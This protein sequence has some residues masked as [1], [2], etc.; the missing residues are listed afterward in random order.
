MGCSQASKINFTDEEFKYFQSS[1]KVHKIGMA[2]ESKQKK[3]IILVNGSLHVHNLN[4]KTLDE[5]RTAADAMRSLSGSGKTF[6]CSPNTRISRIQAEV[7]LSYFNWSSGL[8]IPW[9]PF[10][11]RSTIVNF[12]SDLNLTFTNEQEAEEWEAAIK[13]VINFRY[14]TNLLH[15]SRHSQPFFFENLNT[16]VWMSISAGNIAL[17]ELYTNLVWELDEDGIPIDRKDGAAALFDCLYINAQNFTSDE[18]ELTLVFLFMLHRICQ[19]PLERCFLLMFDIT[20]TERPDSS[21]STGILDSNKDDL[22]PVVKFLKTTIASLPKDKV[23]RSTILH[24]FGRDNKESCISSCVDWKQEIE[25]FT[26]AINS[27]RLSLNGKDLVHLVQSPEWLLHRCLSHFL[28]LASSPAHQVMIM[29]AIEGLSL[30]LLVSRFQAHDHLENDRVGTHFLGLVFSQSLSDSDRKHIL[31]K[32]AKEQK[33]SNE[34]LTAVVMEG[35]DCSAIHEM[36]FALRCMIFHDPD[37]YKMTD[38]HPSYLRLM[39]NFSLV[40]L[41]ELQ[42]ARDEDCLNQNMDDFN[43]LLVLL[44]RAEG[45]KGR[46]NELRLMSDISSWLRIKDAK[47]DH[48][49]EKQ[50][51]K[52][53][54]IALD[55]NRYIGREYGPALVSFYNDVPRSSVSQ[56]FSVLVVN[57]I[58]L[59]FWQLTLEIVGNDF[60]LFLDRFH[61]TAFTSFLKKASSLRDSMKKLIGDHYRLNFAILRKIED[62]ELLNNSRHFTAEALGLLKISHMFNDSNTFVPLLTTVLKLADYENLS[63]R[64]QTIMANLIKNRT[65]KLVQMKKIMAEVNEKRSEEAMGNVTVEELYSCACNAVSAISLVQN[66]VRND[67]KNRLAKL[68]DHYLQNNQPSMWQKLFSSAH[69]IAMFIKYLSRENLSLAYQALKSRNQENPLFMRLIAE[70]EQLYDKPV[71]SKEELN[72]MLQVND[73]D[74]AVDQLLES[75]NAEVENNNVSVE[76][77]MIVTLGVAWMKHM[78]KIL[79][80][81]MPPRNVQNIVMLMVIQWIKQRESGGVGSK[82]FIA[83]VGTGEGKSLMIAMTAVYFAV[84]LKKKV[85][86]LENNIGLLEKDMAQFEKFYETFDLKVDKNF[87]NYSGKADITYTLRRDME[88]FYRM[89]TTEGNKP[90]GNTMLIVDEVDELIVDGDPNQAYVREGSASLPVKNYIDTLASN[91]SASM[92]SGGIK[93]LWDAISYGV[94]EAKSLKEGSDYRVL[95]DGSYCVV[96]EGQLKQ[97]TYDINLEILRYLNER[98]SYNPKV[99]TRFY[100]QSMPHMLLQYEAILGFSGSLG[101]P[102]EREYLASQYKAWCFDVPSYLDTC[103]N[104]KKP[105]AKLLK[106]RVHVMPTREESF[107][108]GIELAVEKSKNVPVLIITDLPD[109]AHGLTPKVVAALQIQLQKNDRTAQLPQDVEVKDMVQTLCRYDEKGRSMPWLTIIDKATEQFEGTS[110]RRITVTDP[111]GGRGH[112][113]MVIDEEA[114]EAGGLFVIILCMPK[115]EREWI[116]W[117]GR[118]ARNDR[119]GQY[120]L[121]LC[122][123]DAPINGNDDLLNAHV[124][125][126]VNT[127]FRPSLIRAMLDEIDKKVKENLE[128]MKG[129]IRKGLILNELCDEF[130]ANGMDKNEDKKMKLTAHLNLGVEG[131]ESG[132]MAAFR[133]SIGLSYS[134]KYY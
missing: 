103:E 113:F 79:T 108:K 133:S 115:S 57:S 85:H 105:K 47:R 9:L 63:V 116:Q 72:M 128:S 18:K 8:I 7:Q 121:V 125:V 44:L 15:S 12:S 34:L 55:F 89:Q 84:I 132:K 2:K 6:L 21:S 22:P 4:V 95:H 82:A 120:A 91:S 112:D 75:K 110:L 60:F 20:P 59:G 129:K 94:R 87:D 66:N 49:L 5:L 73:A 86:V 124:H 127:E 51:I 106:D 97:N 102:A 65:T 41:G 54:L 83:Q 26:S 69:T 71:V 64:T 109:T 117:L 40:I 56:N 32:L 17:L 58:V 45:C 53:L 48:E 130:Y 19:D 96:E 88:S 61:G 119:N 98:N 27:P 35:R 76:R 118:T 14:Y 10:K 28:H 31:Q 99:Q 62:N 39:K 1:K 11:G 24:V 126:L 131:A 77:R 30:S 42:K 68:F 107:K 16:L 25:W 81:P 80:I 104:V 123:E 13:E 3:H 46:A 122:I 90:F 101:S 78:R 100:F 29:N 70:V 93:W 50:N 111:F 74:H 92:P 38:F 114:N 67:E 36:V 23:I 52:D 43:E 33:L 37:Q 134:S